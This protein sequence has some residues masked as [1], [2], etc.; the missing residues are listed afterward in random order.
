MS[1]LVDQNFR[2]KIA[3]AA[4]GHK[5]IVINDIEFMRRL[6]NAQPSQGCKN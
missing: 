5:V 6:I 2:G 4:S 1:I 3:H